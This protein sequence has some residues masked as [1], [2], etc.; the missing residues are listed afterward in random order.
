MFK[1]SSLRAVV[2]LNSPSAIMS[3]N[4]LPLLKW[5]KKPASKALKAGD[6][7]CRNQGL[8]TFF[9]EFCG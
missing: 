8:L 9:S 4:I 3:L 2:E 6:K 7:P 5:V 1:A